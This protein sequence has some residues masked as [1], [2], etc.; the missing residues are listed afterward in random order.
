MT[1]NARNEHDRIKFAQDL[2]ESIYE[3]DEME[4]LRIESELE[5]QKSSRNARS[6]TNGGTASGNSENRDSGVADVDNTGQYQLTS[7]SPS[8]YHQPEVNLKR[9]TLSN[10]LLDMNEQC[11]DVTESS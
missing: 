4:Q 2:Q 1:F 7:T 6:S 9:N 8:D 11:K 10:S 3:M 5:R